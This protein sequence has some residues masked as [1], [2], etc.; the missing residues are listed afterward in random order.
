M[1]EDQKGPELTEPLLTKKGF[2]RLAN[3]SH[4]TVENWEAKG[5]GPPSIRL[6][7]R[8]IRYDPQV[9]RE[10]LRQRV[11]RSTSDLGSGC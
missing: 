9:V 11:R 10:W 4:R 6:S 3:V 7:P 8:C 2:A 1:K 5:T